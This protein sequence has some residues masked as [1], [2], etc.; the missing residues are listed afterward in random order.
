VWRRSL[1]TSPE[2]LAILA[3]V[4]L[5]QLGAAFYAY[6]LTRLTGGFRA[7]W[8][9]IIALLFLSERSFVAFLKAL[10][11]DITFNMPILA[12]LDQAVIPVTI[13][14]VILA[15]MYDLN[16]TFESKKKQAS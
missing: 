14:L 8:L 15:A 13:A 3:V 2:I 6:R 9:L 5:I 4:V 10:G 16:K 11:I 1:S 12:V 7:W